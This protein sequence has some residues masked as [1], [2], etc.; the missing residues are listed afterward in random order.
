MSA[1]STDELTTARPHSGPRHATTLLG[2]ARRLQAQ[3]EQVHP[4]LAGAYRRRGAELRLQAWALAVRSSA[5]D[6]DRFSAVA[7]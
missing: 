2:R 4:L 3:A 5:I 6:V 7:A 1:T